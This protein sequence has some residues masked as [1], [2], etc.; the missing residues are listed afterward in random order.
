LEALNVAVAL[1]LGILEYGELCAQEAI[2]QVLRGQFGPL[3][4]AVKGKV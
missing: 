4:V 1:Q 3:G 2:R